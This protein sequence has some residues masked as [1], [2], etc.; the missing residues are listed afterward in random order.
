MYCTVVLIKKSCLII[1]RIQASLFIL[2]EG[3]HIAKKL[4]SNSSAYKYTRYVTLM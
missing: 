3:N 4:K 1:R 2:L